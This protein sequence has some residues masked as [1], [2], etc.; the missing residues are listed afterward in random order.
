MSYLESILLSFRPVFKRRAAFLWFVILT[1]GF[2][3]RNDYYGVTSVVRALGLPPDTYY[4]LLH[5]FQSAA[6]TVAGLLD[7]WQR[8]VLQSDVAC[9]VNGRYVIIC[10]HTNGVKDAR[11]M[12]A[13]ATIHQ[14]SETA[15]K[16]SFFRGHKWA[17]LGLLSQTAVKCLS[18]PLWTEIHPSDSMD[19]QAV[20]PVAKAIEISRRFSIYAY[21]VVDAFFAVGPVF[22]K[23]Q[24]SEGRVHIVTRA[25][26]NIVAYEFPPGRKKGRGR[27]RKYGKKVKLNKLFESKKKKFETAYAPIYGRNEKIKYLVLNLIWKPARGVLRFFLVKSSRGCI[28]IMTS[29]LAMDVQSACF[30]YCRRATIETFFDILKNLLGGMRYHF[31]S[32]YLP[33]ISRRPKKNEGKPVSSNEDKTRNT[34]TAIEKFMAIQ[35]IVAGIIQLL[36]IKAPREI[37]AKA[38]CWQRTSTGSEQPSPFVVIAAMRNIVAGLLSGFV[39]NWIS[40]LIRCKRKN[41]HTPSNYRMTS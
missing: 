3:V 7:C 32:K 2:L 1:L 14:D 38:R 9:Q 34:L 26:K 17:C 16:P 25:K 10:D 35:V 41:R 12:P 39:K 22:L 13:V 20:R 27:P 29:N 19:S 23:A 28:I 21:L 37:S 31:W 18:M 6:F 11:K 24:E 4:S 15:S 5:F 33:P 36:S 30:L 40:Q 8:W